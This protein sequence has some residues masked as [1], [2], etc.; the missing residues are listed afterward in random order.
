MEETIWCALTPE[1]PAN[2]LS[3][4]IQQGSDRLGMPEVPD[5]EPRERMLRKY[6]GRG[7]RG[8]KRT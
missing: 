5:G 3:A 1:T 4:S 2:M 8:G 6:R 7:V